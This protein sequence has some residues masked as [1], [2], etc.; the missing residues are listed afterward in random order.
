MHR[1]VLVLVACA[2]LVVTV[3]A[4]R[5]ITP[6]EPRPPA[7]A[8]NTRETKR[9]LIVQGCVFD[10]RLLFDGSVNINA[11]AA[12][13]ADELVLEGPKELLRQIK[14][15]HDG[16]EEQISGIVT[17][18]A[19]DERD[20]LSTTKRVGPKTI[21]TATASQEPKPDLTKPDSNKVHR[22]LHL[23]VEEVRHIQDKCPYA[24]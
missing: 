15:K 24:F 19:G 17:I 20:T 16:H 8:T 2:G 12:L 13:L 1:R 10:R 9:A 3:R 11:A 4:Q 14:A 7:T 21:I 18:P 6:P 22:I 5:P 23:K